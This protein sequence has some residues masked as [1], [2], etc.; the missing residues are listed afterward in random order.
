M[1]QDHIKDQD[2]VKDIKPYYQVRWTE[3]LVYMFIGTLER[4][5]K[6]ELTN[7]VIKF[8]MI[9]APNVSPR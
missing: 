5:V 2:H 3:T 1:D 6:Y 9:L 7:E 4:N 8:F